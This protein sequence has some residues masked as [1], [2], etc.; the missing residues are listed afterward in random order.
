[1]LILHV[2]HEHV[3]QG[4][5]GEKMLRFRRDNG[6]LVVGAFPDFAGGCD[7]RNAV[8][9][10]N[11]GTHSGQRYTMAYFNRFFPSIL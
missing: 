1:M 10:N 5:A 11:D 4:C 2:A 3:H 9:N 7:P 6:D 8:A